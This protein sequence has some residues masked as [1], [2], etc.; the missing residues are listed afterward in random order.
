MG[1][2]IALLLGPARLVLAA[3]AYE[4]APQALLVNQV[5]TRN[6]GGFGLGLWVA[7]SMGVPPEAARGT[8]DNPRSTGTLCRPFEGSSMTCMADLPVDTERYSH[9]F[10][11]GNVGD[12]WKHVVWGALLAALAEEARSLHIVETHAGEGAYTLGPTGEWT[13]GIGRVWDFAQGKDVPWALR[14][15]LSLCDQAEGR[16]YPGSPAVTAA[17]LRDGDR[18]ALYEW[19]AAACARL[20]ENMGDDVAGVTVHGGDGLAALAELTCAAGAQPVV[21]IDPP[22]SA[23]EDWTEVPTALAN[24]YDAH[25]AMCGVLWYPIKSYTRPNAMLELLGKRKLPAVAVEIVTTPLKLQRN[26]LNGSG[27]L[28]VNAPSAVISAVLAAA[29][30]LGEACATHGGHWAVRVHRV[31]I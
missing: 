5:S 23:K 26:R 4:P 27:M 24:A 10:H 15:L 3:V 11:A 1:S 29:P 8:L 22:Y 30:M 31:E 17:Y 12:V 25:P 28:L 7:R 6:Y 14:A 2:T 18:A 21:F 13:A 20:L 9:R 16:T 19:D